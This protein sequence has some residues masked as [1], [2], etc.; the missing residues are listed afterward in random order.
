MKRLLAG[1]LTCL[2]LTG[3]ALTAEKPYVPTSGVQ[4]DLSVL[5]P[6][7][8]PEEIAQRRSPERVEDLTAGDYGLLR[9]YIGSRAAFDM[10]IYGNEG[11][12]NGSMGLIDENG[13]IV[14]DPVYTDVTLLTQW[15]D[16][17][18]PKFWRLSKEV[19]KENEWG[20]YMEQLHG[21]CTLDGSVVEPCIYES[22]NYQYGYIIACNRAKDGLL[23]IFDSQGKL[24]LDTES[25]TERFPIYSDMGYSSVEVSENLL[26]LGVT[27][28][29]ADYGMDFWLC[30]WEGNVLSKDYDYVT[31]SGEAPYACGTWDDGADGYIDE[32][33]NLLRSGYESVSEYHDGQ[34]IVNQ[35]GQQ[36]VIDTDGNVLWTSD[37]YY[38]YT[39]LSDTTVYYQEPFDDELETGSYR[40]YNKDFELMFPEADHVSWMYDDWFLVWQ[41]G[42]GTLTDG[43]RSA[44][45]DGAVLNNADFYYGNDMGV[46][47]LIMVTTWGE[48][49]QLW[50]LFHEEPQLLAKDS[51]QGSGAAILPDRLDGNSVAVTYDGMTYPVKYSALDYPGAPKLDNVYVLNVYDGWYMVEDEFS[52][53]Y[54]DADGNWLFRVS[55]MED[56]ID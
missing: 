21:F 13:A 2:L 11:I 32:Y 46:D 52:A 41:N 20:T 10:T 49:G 22:I 8:P 27:D 38:L 47:D 5:E 30:D 34:A 3:C 53:G 50:W 45:L 16:A 24:L 36:Q 42:I 18:A 26:F 35:G 37:A 12:Y 1:L 51:D 56:M 55:L 25:W 28:E 19:Q 54:M 6:F 7:A 14:V 17:D 15:D 39:C 44:V 9:P 43:T 23:R 29:T 31:L 40:Y 4:M 48:T 33:G